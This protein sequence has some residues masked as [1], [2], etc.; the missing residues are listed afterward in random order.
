MEID[1]S[2]IIKSDLMRGKKG[3][4]F[5]VANER[6]IAWTITRYIVENGGE[7]VL[8]CLEGMEKRVA[9]LTQTL[10]QKIEIITCDLTD[11]SDIKNLF[12]V[13]AEKWQTLDFIVHAVAFSNKNELKELYINCTLE[14]F[15]QSMH[16]SCYSFTS[17]AQHA[18]PLMQEH[19]GSMITLSYYGSTKVIP[20]YN[21]MGV[22]KAALE[23][24]VRYL[25]C[26]LG[27]F[28]IRVNCLSAGP[29]RTLA[30]AAIG[31]FK[32]ILKWNKYNSPLRRN[33]TY[34]D[35]GGAALYL[36]SDLSSGTTG[37][38]LYVDSGYN[39][40]GMKAVDAPDLT[41][42]TE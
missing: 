21:V 29:M 22:C 1:N 17:L 37:E 35:V 2:S 5:G 19:G 30:S 11:D 10:Q 15:L 28:N 40:I 39:I 41:K 9:S 32:Y 3:L 31:D 38:I 18:M 25:A 4:V 42:Q 34:Q 26:D 7:V 14:N 16:I 13:V 33:T 23:A 12:T 8:A 24:S 27:K 6:S 36:L 20:H